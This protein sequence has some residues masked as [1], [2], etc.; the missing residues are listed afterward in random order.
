MLK[1]KALKLCH[2]FIGSSIKNL[3]I[4][5]E[6]RILQHL[7]HSFGGKTIF[8]PLSLLSEGNADPELPES[9]TCPQDG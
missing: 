2:W 8:Q 9:E 1:K 5:R 3:Q 4:Y 7:E 6:S